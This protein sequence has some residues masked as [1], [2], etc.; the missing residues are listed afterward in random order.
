MILVRLLP[1]AGLSKSRKSTRNTTS[2]RNNG[3]EL[4]I[5]GGK[6]TINK[7]Y[8]SNR[9]STSR[10]VASNF[11]LP[12]VGRVPRVLLVL[13]IMVMSLIILAVVIRVMLLTTATIGVLIGLLPVAGPSR[14]KKSTSNTVST[15]NIGMSL[16]VMAI[17]LRIRFATATTLI[18][19]VGLLPVVG[20][21]RSR[22]STRSTTNTRN[23]D[24][25]PDNNG[26]IHTNNM[27]N[28]SNSNRTSKPAASSW[29]SQM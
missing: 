24:N 2:T 19:L 4:A 9:N 8:H 26:R 6:N 23:N 15:R 13:E 25:Q 12:R 21:A 20:P 5:H 14:S 1:V 7:C 17:I 18:V 28:N 11:F 29:S 27:R 10:P 3:N 22:T 16:I